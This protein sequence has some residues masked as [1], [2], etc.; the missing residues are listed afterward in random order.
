[1]PNKIYR[2]GLTMPNGDII[3]GI[4]RGVSADGELHLETATKACA[5]L[6]REKLESCSK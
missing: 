2:F 4:G 3:N 5:G 6:T 1:M